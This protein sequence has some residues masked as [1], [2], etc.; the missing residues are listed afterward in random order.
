VVIVMLVGVSIFL[1]IFMYSGGRYSQ[2]FGN[3]ESAAARPVLWSAATQIALDHPLLG[4]GHNRFTEVSPEYLRSINAALLTN[5]A[6]FE[7]IGKYEPHNDLL[8]VWSSFGT[9]AALAFVLLIWFSARNFMS[10]A[11]EFLDPTLR[12]ISLGCLGALVA[13]IVNSMFHNFYDSTL[14][15]WLLAGM[16]MAL[17]KL[18]SAEAPLK[19]PMP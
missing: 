15:L 14:T 12:A 10:A 6:A 11:R 3:D 17:T 16:S 1:G 9:G 19:K 13:I 5:Q 4:I 2:S 8:N 18:A 7:V